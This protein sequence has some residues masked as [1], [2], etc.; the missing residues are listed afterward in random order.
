MKTKGQRLIF[1]AFGI[2]EEGLDSDDGNTEELL[3]WDGSATTCA[4]FSVTIA[5]T[6]GKSARL[7]NTDYNG[8]T[9]NNNYKR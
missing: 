5:D 9:K 4:K 3:S 6:E 2:T 1:N 8:N 7:I